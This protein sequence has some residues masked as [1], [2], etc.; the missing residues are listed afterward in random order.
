LE[1]FKTVDEN[2][3]FTLIHCWILIKIPKSGK[4]PRPFGK[5][6]KG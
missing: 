3:A 1:D 2:K 4:L 6:I 5:K